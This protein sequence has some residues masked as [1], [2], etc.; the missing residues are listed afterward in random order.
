VIVGLFKPSTLV[1]K[2]F[3]LFEQVFLFEEKLTG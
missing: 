1:I 3:L 2:F